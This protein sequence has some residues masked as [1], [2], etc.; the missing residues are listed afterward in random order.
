MTVESLPVDKGVGDEVSSGTVNQF[1]AFE[2]KATKVG[3]DSSIQRMT[4]LVQSA[5][6]DKAKIVGLSDRWAT[7]IVVIALT[8]A[9]LTWLIS[10]EIIRAVTILVVFCPCALVLATPTAIMAPSATRRS[11]AFSSARVTRLSVSPP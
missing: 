7:W 5:D 4:R 6:A 3:E 2:M 11:T 9:A 8:A 1:G 10:G